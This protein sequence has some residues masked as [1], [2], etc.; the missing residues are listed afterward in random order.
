MVQPNC[1]VLSSQTFLLG[2][3]GNSLEQQFDRHMNLKQSVKSLTNSII[4][5]LAAL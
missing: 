1:S 3:I 2:R 4:Y 5:L